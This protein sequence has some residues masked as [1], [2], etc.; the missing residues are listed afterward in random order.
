MTA[1]EEKLLEALRA[2][3]MENERLRLE[4]H[5]L[6]TAAAEPVAVVGMACRLPGGVSSPEELWRLVAA[7]GEGI[8]A[9]PEDRGWDLENL[10]NPSADP[11]VDQP[12]KTYVREA[13]FLRDAAG[14]D[15]AF[16]GISDREALAMDP[17]QR[18]L[19]ELSWEVFERAG[20]VPASVRG[21]SVGVFAGVMYH[22]YAPRTGRIP[23]E[24]EGHLSV[25]NSGSAATG[26]V[27]YVL[28]LEGP[29]V[30]VETACSSSLVAMHLAMQALRLGECEM[31]LAGGVTVMAL[32]SAF[33]EFSRQRALARDGRIKAF[34]AA[35]DGT[36]W[37]EG[38]GLV[39]LERLS[40]AR[41][42]GHQVL[43]VVRGSAV[44][45]DGASNGLTAPN[46]PSQ[47]RVIQQ[48]LASARLSPADVDAVEAHGTGTTLGDPIEAQA[49]LATYGRD[50]PDGR[51][52]W[53]G[54]LKSNIGHTQAAAGVAGVI[55]MILAMQHGT[56]P[57]TLHVDQPTPKVDWSA[58]TVQ[59][60]TRPQP[61]PPGTSPRRAAISSFG[62]SGTNAHLI[63]EQAPPPP[64]AA[65][66]PPP[67]TPAHPQPW[68]LS[69]KTPQALR[70]QAHQLASF[71][72]S[73]PGLTPAGI[74]CSLAT[75]RTAFDHRAVIIAADHDTYLSHL[76]ALAHSQ[77]APGLI[78]G[79][80]A[81]GKLAFLFPGQGSQQPGMGRELHAAF[82]AYAQAFDAACAELDHH[83]APHVTWPLRD[84]I[85]AEPGT[86]PAPHLHD[87]IY[88]QAAL[89]AVE[90]ALYRLLESWGLHPD[91]L[92][93]HSIGE[94]AAAHA[95]GVLTLTDAC[96][97][98]AARGRLMQTL[99]PGG[100]MIAIQAAEAEITPLLPPQLAIAAING[101][102]SIVISGDET[103]ATALAARFTANGRRAKRLNVSHA[104]HSP[105]IDPILTEFH[106]IASTL[107]YN[108]PTIP[109]ISNLTG[110][111]ATPAQLCSPD[112]W[113]RHARDP[114]RFADT[115]HWLDTHTTTTY[116]ETGPGT[117]LTTIASH[118]L[119]PARPHT[120]ATPLHPGHAETHATITALAHLH[121]RG[122][123][124]NWPALFPHHQ[125]PTHLP[126]YPFQH[127]HYWLKAGDPMNEIR[128][129]PP[130]APTPPRT[131]LAQRLSELKG[132][133]QRLAL[134]KTVIAEAAAMPREKEDAEPIEA[135]S[136][137]FEIGFN[138]LAAVELRNRLAEATGLELNP[139]LLFDYPTPEQVTDF[140]LELLLEESSSV[141]GL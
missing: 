37:S 40:D 26:R 56:L 80:A 115:L 32:P 83:L 30:T 34:A 108:L 63:L 124:I 116:L 85:F 99:P 127:H 41:S 98:A 140:L 54:S 103:A 122:T 94:L 22:D 19:L 46:G 24:V 141:S 62:V 51:P 14:F 47:Q 113:V 89:F 67:A 78:T 5:R 138:S 118:C 95:A 31:A 125:H 15:P 55:K 73:N 110:D 29:A 8:S 4:N 102:A 50:R 9:F 104:F 71:A 38:A 119:T 82:P 59:L 88:T 68:I 11:A 61:W 114:V 58:G 57:M 93:G 48:A 16:F 44:N 136:P 76:T 101:P 65:P 84:V 106:T 121:T 112:Y 81:G 17:Q 28:G 126:T 27:A 97:L 111:L 35:A 49:L 129:V 96:A 92:A 53:L 21:R 52:L 12:G 86:P 109:I 117:T 123:P 45:Q 25:G 79:T 107:T 6:A 87:T 60:L 3:V 23:K 133:D 74:G 91:Y 72:A 39:L 105:R 100:T 131:P 13:G 75:T 70:A 36:G 1:R 128:Q 64:P 69:A 132:P 77:P 2:S 33:V 42:R 134:L 120:Y 18:L 130:E 43:A 10:F 135:D 137:F 139:M 7:G 20:I 90:T 66:G